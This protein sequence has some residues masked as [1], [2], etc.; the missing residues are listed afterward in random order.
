MDVNALM[1]NVDVTSPDLPDFLWFWIFYQE[2]G[3][4]HDFIR[5]NLLY[6]NDN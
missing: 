5:N 4:L 6:Y 3:S 1:D 2:I